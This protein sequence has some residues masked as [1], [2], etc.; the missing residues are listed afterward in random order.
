MSVSV[1]DHEVSVQ[2]H[3]FGAQTATLR[4]QN[5]K[6][7]MGLAH[8]DRHDRQIVSGGYFYVQL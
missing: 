1:L 6:C 3:S 5:W 8:A 7:G 4:G 2:F